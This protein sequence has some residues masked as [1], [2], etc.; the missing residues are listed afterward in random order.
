MHL[1]HEPHPRV[2]ALEELHTRVGGAA[3]ARA[4][5][6]QQVL[7]IWLEHALAEEDRAPRALL[8][9]SRQQRCGRCSSI[10]SGA[11]LRRRLN[12]RHHGRRFRASRE[13]PEGVRQLE[14]RARR[15]QR[16][17]DADRCRLAQLEDAQWRREREGGRRA[18]LPCA[19]GCADLERVEHQLRGHVLRSKARVALGGL[20]RLRPRRQLDRA[21]HRVAICAA[22][23][24]AIRCDRRIRRRRHIRWPPQRHMAGEA[25]G[26]LALGPIGRVLA[27]RELLLLVMLR[28]VLLRVR[29]QKFV[30]HGLWRRVRHATD[31]ARH[32]GGRARHHPRT[33][34]RPPVPA[35]D[36]AG[37]LSAPVD[38]RGHERSHVCGLLAAELA[39]SI[40]LAEVGRREQCVP[41]HVDTSNGARNGIGWPRVGAVARVDTDVD[42]RLLAALPTAPAVQAEWADGRYAQRLRERI[43]V[44]NARW[45]RLHGRKHT[46]RSRDAERYEVVPRCSAHVDDVKTLEW[47]PAEA[48][49]VLREFEAGQ[50]CGLSEHLQF[51]MRRRRHVLCDFLVDSDAQQRQLIV[52]CNKVARPRCGAVVVQKGA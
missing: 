6:A 29:G 27:R 10:S 34:Q 51:C 52:V 36:E 46:F 9:G 16:A 42:E 13:W 35:G 39:K 33:K 17:L 48:Q 32:E 2:D 20:A 49:A 26:W 8:P 44:I 38:D 22:V 4:H 45:Q 3:L 41:T 40:A 47:W 37:R 25:A 50:I 15:E 5:L 18:L 14:L 11:I 21:A 12:G 30:E 28:D 23:L 43:E 31:G 24:D 1:H 19:V 7:H